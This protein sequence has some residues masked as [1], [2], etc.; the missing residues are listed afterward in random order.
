MNRR[1]G[2]PP[3]K[4]LKKAQPRDSR[5][6]PALPKTLIKIVV[7]VALLALSAVVAIGFAVSHLSPARYSR[8]KNAQAVAA[9]TP[10]PSPVEQEANLASANLQTTHP[11]AIASED[12][13]RDQSPL[14]TP[15]P[16][17]T[18]LPES[19]PIVSDDRTPDVKR[20]EAD[21]KNVERERRVAERKRSRLE[22]MYQRHEISSET[23]KKGQDEYQSEMAKYRNALHGAEPTNE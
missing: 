7:P 14:P 13:A 19:T 17:A 21:R 6:R 3:R 11:A 8:S 9:M 15:M 12:P 23:Y 22:A 4:R 10:S 16:N 5:Q 2:R 1:R 18:P 20:S